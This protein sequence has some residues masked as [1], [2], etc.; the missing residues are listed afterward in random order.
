MTININVVDL[1][2]VAMVAVTRADGPPREGR[3][4]H[5][6]AGTLDICVCSL[7]LIR[8]KLTIRPWT[9]LSTP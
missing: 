5:P 7:I 1:K 8:K 4:A 3:P 9:R 2:G 6:G